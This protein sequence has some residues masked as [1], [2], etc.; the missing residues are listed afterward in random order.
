MA[1]IIIQLFFLIYPTTVLFSQTKTKITHKTSIDISKVDY[2]EIY[3]LTKPI[4]DSTFGKII[5]V[6]SKDQIKNFAEAW[7]SSSY[8]GLCKFKPSYYINIYL[9]DG[10]KRT[11]KINGSIY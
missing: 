1:K 5:H 9:K 11:F 6:L 10:S 3:K 2:A 8:N 4:E 7:N